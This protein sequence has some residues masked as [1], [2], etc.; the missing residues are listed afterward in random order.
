MSAL[1]NIAVR[2]EPAGLLFLECEVV[3]YGRGDEDE[4]E[5]P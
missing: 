2:G 3:K 4:R 5:Q 1:Q